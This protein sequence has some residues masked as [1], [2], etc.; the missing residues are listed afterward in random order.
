MKTKNLQTL[1]AAIGLLGGSLNAAAEL[2]D[3]PY[4][5][6]IGAEGDDVWMCGT[7][8]CAGTQSAGDGQA[9]FTI[10]HG[11]PTGTGYIDPFLRFQHNEPSGEQP[12]DFEAAYNTDAR[13]LQ[14]AGDKWGYDNQAK[15]EN[16][17]NHSLKLGE[18]AEDGDG[19]YTFLLD[20][21]EPGGDK[22]TITID[23]L[24]FFVANAGDFNYYVRDEAPKNGGSTDPDEDPI[25]G[26]ELW[27]DEASETA[28]LSGL[29]YQ[30]EK[31]WDLDWDYTKGDACGADNPDFPTYGGCGGIT[32]SSVNDPNGGNG[33]GD[34]DLMLRI[35]KSL[36]WISGATADSYVY[37]YNFLGSIDSKQNLYEEAEA[38]FEEW[39][40]LVKNDPGTSVPE[41][42]TLGLLL[43][44]SV[45][46]F[47]RC[48]RRR[49]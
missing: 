16:H 37:L 9:Q 27:L 44:G 11:M 32:I 42:A 38:G 40:A 22:S 28:N 12:K 4:Y 36:F 45:A 25:A 46:G 21:N 33:S 24:Q 30:A 7:S 1:V 20:V 34:W 17:W 13:P 23:E 6:L 43:L 29:D 47:R 3:P 35:P 49:T 15:D 8:D 39:K 31:V 41:P 19:M 48:R 14:R 26:G 5:S 10:F 18:L 2:N